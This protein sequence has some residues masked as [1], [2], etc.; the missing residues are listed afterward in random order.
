MC[1][2]C[3]ETTVQE[4]VEA[5]DNHGLLATASPAARQRVRSRVLID[6]VTVILREVFQLVV[7]LTS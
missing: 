2:V 7:V 6:I 4:D 1:T 3:G 5:E